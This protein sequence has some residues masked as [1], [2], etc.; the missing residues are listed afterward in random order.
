M[1]KRA[2]A[3]FEIKSWDENPLLE[4]GGQKLTRARVRKS[5]RGD[6]EGEGVIEYLMF[7]RADGTAA[8]TGIERITGRLDGKNGSFALLHGG[9]F[10]DGVATSDITVIEG[11]GIEDLA[12]LHGKGRFS[13]GHTPPFEMTLNYEVGRK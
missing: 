9:T 2:V 10:V 7:Y 4:D 13:V 1:L 8:F 6:I 5:F 11:S 12:G 3:T